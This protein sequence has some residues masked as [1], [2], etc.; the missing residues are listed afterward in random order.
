[1]GEAAAVRYL[2]QIGHKILAINWRYKK[3][4]VDIIS[5]WENTIVFIEVKTRKSLTFGEPELFVG[6]KKQGF[7]VAAANEYML[8]NN[9]PLESRFDIVAI[10]WHSNSQ[11]V[12]HLPEAFYPPV[13]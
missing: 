9:L 11:V 10:V 3:Y 4:E 7:L 1:M 2:E 12:K 5:R 13:K 6:R 8:Q